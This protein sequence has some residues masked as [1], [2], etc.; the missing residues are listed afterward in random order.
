MKKYDP[1]QPRVPAGHSQG[2]QWTNNNNWS[3]GG[4]AADRAA[5]RGAGL[6]PKTMQ[7]EDL[8]LV[9]EWGILRD[10]KLLM[11]DPIEDEDE[12]QY[13]LE[14]GYVTPRRGHEYLGSEDWAN[15]DLSRFLI[16]GL[17]GF[18]V[19]PETNEVKSVVSFYLFRGRIR[20]RVGN[21]LD[22]WYKY[23]NKI[24]DKLEGRIM[25]FESP[26]IYYS[27]DAFYYELFDPR[28]PP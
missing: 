1:N 23:Q 6:M 11:S 17:Y 12:I 14:Q 8:R 25:N 20:S 18:Y 7:Q 5:R 15:H 28:K 26:T 27:R 21:E 24:L 22:D 4:D 19:H 9:G 3:R 16:R 13:Y 2:G 10:G